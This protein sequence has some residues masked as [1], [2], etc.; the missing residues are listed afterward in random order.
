MADW[1]KPGI[2]PRIHLRRSRTLAPK[3][4]LQGWDPRAAIFN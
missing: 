2:V 1:T 4:S 3:Q